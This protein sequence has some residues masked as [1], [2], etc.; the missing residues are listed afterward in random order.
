MGSL[1]DFSCLESVQT[2][3]RLL[4]G[5]PIQLARSPPTVLPL[6]IVSITL[7]IETCDDQYC[8]DFIRQIADYPT[9]FHQ[10]AKITVIGVADVDAEEV[11]RE[12]LIRVL[13]KKGTRFAF[14]KKGRVECSKG[15][16]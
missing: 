13:E 6:S 14:E 1:K 7:H 15:W 4:I 11:F 12:G 3:L 8:D 9:H 2:D 10:L 16:A 5:N